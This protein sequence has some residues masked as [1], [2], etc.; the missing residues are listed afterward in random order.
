MLF[1][2]EDDVSSGS[3]LNVRTGTLH[4][5][6]IVRDVHSVVFYYIDG[7]L[8]HSRRLMDGNLGT[9]NMI[10]HAVSPFK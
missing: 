10:V 3:S 5:L 4:R 2:D 1:T 7:A 8:S 6:T 9:L